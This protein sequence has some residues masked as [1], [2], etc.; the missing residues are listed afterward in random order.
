MSPSR[1]DAPIVPPPRRFADAEAA[2][3]ATS[4]D[5]DVAGQRGRG[6]LW[7]LVGGSGAI[8]VILAIVLVVV[9]AARPHPG[10]I[11]TAAPS[12]T[13]APRTTDTTRNDAG[14]TPTATAAPDL[15][16]APDPVGPGMRVPITTNALL[17]PGLTL[18]PPPEAGWT[19][20]TII[21][22]PDQTTLVSPSKTQ[23]VDVWQPGVALTRQSD[24]SITRAQLNRAADD[25]RV[26]ASASAVRS[27]PSYWL[28]GSDGT[29]IELLGAIVTG[30]DGGEMIVYERFMPQS[31]TRIHIALWSQNGADDPVLHAQLGAISFTRP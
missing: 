5:R 2:A 25:C 29:S 8:V 1:D 24:E 28:T 13:G 16:V 31:G 9:G 27:A 17:D 7:I 30:C 23:R 14:R 6:L 15:T 10:A 11:T 26:P 20:T 21:N 4:G 18:V 3:R 22:R 19:R 12:S